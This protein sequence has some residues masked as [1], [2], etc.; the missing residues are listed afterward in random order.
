MGALAL[1]IALT[2][3]PATAGAWVA[4]NDHLSGIIGSQTSSN[5]T[6]Y[7]AMTGSGGP[8][9]NILNGQSITASVQINRAGT[10]QEGNGGSN[11]N[12]G[13]DAAITFNGYVYFGD[14]HNIKITTNDSLYYTFTNLTPSRS[15]SFAGTTVR[16]DSSFQL[17]WSL[18]EILGTADGNTAFAGAHTAGARIITNGAPFNP[19]AVAPNG[20]AINSGDNREGDVARWIDIKPASNGTFSIRCTQYTGPIPS[21]GSATQTLSYAIT[22]FRLEEFETGPSVA[23]TSPSDNQVF[24]AP[25]DIAV[26]V[27]TTDTGATVTNL[28]VLANETPIL[29]GTNSPF[30]F[31]WSTST[32]GTY[33]LVAVATDS[34]GLSGTSSPVTVEVRA[35]PPII[36]ALAPVPGSGVPTF[37]SVSVLFNKPVTGVDA[38]DLWVNASPC[39]I[40]DGTGA[41]PYTFSFAQPPQGTVILGWAEGHAIHDLLGTDFTGDPWSVLLDPNIGNTAIGPPYSLAV[42]APSGYLPDVP[43]LVRVELRKSDGSM[44]TDVWDADATLGTS[45]PD[46]M[47]ATNSLHLYNGMGSVMLAATN[48]V[49]FNL[50]VTVGDLRTNLLVASRAYEPATVVAGTLAGTNTTW[51]GV[52]RITGNVTIPSTNTLTILPDTL[53]VINGVTDGIGASIDIQGTLSSLGTEDHPVAFTVST[54]AHTWGELHHTAGS[55]AIFVNTFISKGGRSAASGHTASGPMIRMTGCTNTYDRCSLTDTTRGYDTV[56][57]V[58]TADGGCTLVLTNCLITRSLMGPEVG[59]T[60]VQCDKTYFL[61][62]VGS[63]LAPEG[64]ND[65]DGIYIHDQG[66]RLVKIRNCV[67][68]HTQDDGIDTLGSTIEVENTLIRN[69]DNVNEDSKGISAYGGEV[70]VRRC[71]IVDNKCGISGKDSTAVS[72]FVEA[73]TIVSKVEYA[74]GALNKTGGMFPSVDIRATNCILQTLNANTT[75]VFTSYDPADIRI[76]YSAIGNTWSG[77]TNCILSDPRFIDATNHDYRLQAG[78]PCIDSGDPASS[79][80]PDGSRADMGYFP[81]EPPPPLFLQPSMVDGGF[82]FFLRVTP[83]RNYVV[84]LSTNLIAWDDWFTA[85]CTNEPM[86]VVD[87][88][89]GYYPVRYYRARLADSP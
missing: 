54:N 28:V 66:S 41:G 60:G 35:T 30:S 22:G 50:A 31:T 85:Y 4:F 67:F 74:L 2:Q 26:N 75:A 40:L 17:R 68:A 65:N 73:S 42:T 36:A 16:G 14:A 46:V 20:V 21:G 49:D 87:H 58:M 10:I 69:C 59:A 11:P 76:N 79:L 51:S 45:N 48:T 64:T 84:Q 55:R 18:Y 86:A 24:E 7:N 44:A 39:T 72:I 71:L 52:V 62:L 70:N 32:T 77:A 57:K 33:S 80:D 23:I 29:N 12:A 43:F 82:Q 81:Y 34:L 19:A 27:N 9:K 13:S 38:A 5:A 25:A 53:V 89:A 47:L 63:K 6:T 3:A 83:Y 78:S 15:Y 37:T 8:L 61:D 88:D 1:G 56:G